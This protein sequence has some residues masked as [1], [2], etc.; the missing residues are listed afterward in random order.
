MIEEFYFSE[1]GV[2]RH[3]FGGDYVDRIKFGGGL[4][5]PGKTLTFKRIKGLV[6]L[7]Y[8]VGLF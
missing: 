7:R 2:E 6:L 3:D 8:W 5:L 4:C 1:H